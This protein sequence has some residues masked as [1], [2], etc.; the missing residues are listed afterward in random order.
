MNKLKDTIEEDIKNV[1]FDLND[2]ATKEI[3]DNVE[4]DVVWDNDSSKI[5][6]VDVNIEETNKTFFVPIIQLQKKEIGSLIHIG[7]ED[8]FVVSWN[9]NNGIAE[10]TIKRSE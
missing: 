10:V 8:W 9:E 2:F 6:N 5:L 7:F 3:I 4:V 1:F